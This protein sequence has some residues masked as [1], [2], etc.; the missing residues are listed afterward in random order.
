MHKNRGL[1]PVVNVNVVSDKSNIFV[2]LF[3]FR[4]V[5]RVVVSCSK[6]TLA[7]QLSVKT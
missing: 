2:S 1:L 4:A 7:P 5:F 6:F 3:R